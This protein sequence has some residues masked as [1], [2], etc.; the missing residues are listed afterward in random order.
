MA[1]FAP[2]YVIGIDA[3]TEALKAGIFTLQGELVASAQATYATHFPR[4]G[5]AEQEPDDWWNALVLAV[6]ACLAAA[7]SVQPEEII[8]LSA[9]ATCCTMLPMRRDGTH[10]RPALLWM[11]VRAADQARRIFESGHAALR[12]SLAGVNAEWMPP[13]MLWLKENVPSVW[14]ATDVLVEFTDW[15]AY[16]LTGRFALSIST[17]S[18]RWFYHLP[19]GGWQPDFFA[20]IGL[21]DIERKLPADVLRIG[22]V[23]GPLRADVAAL[24]GLP[25]GIP[26]ATSGA[27]AFIGMLGQGVT[28]PGDLGLITGSSNVLTTLSATEVHFPGIFGAFPESLI[29]GLH[30][31]EGGQVST[32]SILNWFKR[33]FAP[34]VEA[35]AAARGL[36]PYQLLDSEAAQIPPGSE[37]LIVLDSF[38]GNRTPHTDSSARGMI[39]GL[40]LQSSR[41]H[42]FRALMEGIAYGMKDILDAFDRNNVPVERVIAS[43]GATRSPLFMQIYAD[44][45]GKPIY[46]TTQ[47]EA[48]LLGSAVVAA[49]GAGAY[50][51]LVEA[52][53]NMVEE[54]TV[55]Q[56][57]PARHN[58]YRFYAQKYQETY[59]RMKE[60]MREM[61]AHVAEGN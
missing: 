2:P 60:L 29:P 15:I 35:E 36:R 4:S 9:D 42:V 57:D 52:S 38:Q 32:G 25:A 44:V 30:P 50:P 10:L 61:T 46:T 45:L 43:G 26:I 5:W 55:T 21:E 53:R 31:V 48:C 49:M 37:G 18:H 28:A 54:A 33:N 12:Y 6:R 1:G 24:L 11:D 23:V 17:T 59:P 22:E 58:A 47:P 20:A 7:P 8:G 51:T 40:S 34:D 3:G 39:W 16:K 27:D 41:A 56:P 14:E 13:K 19:S